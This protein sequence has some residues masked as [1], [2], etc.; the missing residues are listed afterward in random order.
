MGN[1]STVFLPVLGLHTY[2]VAQIYNLTNSRR[3]VLV[4]PSRKVGGG[5]EGAAGGG[6]AASPQESVLHNF[7][8]FSSLFANTH[9]PLHKYSQFSL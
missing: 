7:S 3:C 5:R 1:T 8:R 6:G 9:H 2:Y 4:A